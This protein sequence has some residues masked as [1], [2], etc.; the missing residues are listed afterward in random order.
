MRSYN[1][2]VTVIEASNSMVDRLVGIRPPSL[3]G[4]DKSSHSRSPGE[5]L[6]PYYV[7]NGCKKHAYVWNGSGKVS[8]LV[9]HTAAKIAC[10]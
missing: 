1:G 7:I 8:L 5:A 4:K 3:G 9:N 2:F 6:L 10:G